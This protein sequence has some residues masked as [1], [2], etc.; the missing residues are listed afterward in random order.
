MIKRI[1]CQRFAGFLASDQVI[2]VATG[3]CGPD[4]FDDH[5]SPPIVLT[6]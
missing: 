5:R 2:E 4:L 3:V 1:D 6:L